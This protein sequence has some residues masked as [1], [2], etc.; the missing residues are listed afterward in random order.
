MQISG[1]QKNSLI[2]YPGAIAC[3]VFTQGCTFR[4]PYCHNPELIPMKSPEDESGRTWTE[5]EILDFLNKRKKLLDG[6]VISG[7]EPTL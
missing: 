6:V 5:K 3:V 2:D 1:F 7:G 4:C